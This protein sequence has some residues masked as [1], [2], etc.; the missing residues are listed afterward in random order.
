MI[1]E[2]ASLG[3]WKVFTS[4]GAGVA[5]GQ[6][7]TG[8][9]ERAFVLGKCSYVAKRTILKLFSIMKHHILLKRPMIQKGSAKANRREPKN[10]RV[11][12]ST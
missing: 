5:L 3:L 12:F 1:I 10:F 9:E 4:L 2:Q 11:E 8:Q 7:E 6:R